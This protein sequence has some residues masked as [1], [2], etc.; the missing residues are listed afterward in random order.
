[1]SNGPQP[2][3]DFDA[4]NKEVNEG[5]VGPDNVLF[6]KAEKQIVHIRWAIR[7]DMQDIVHTEN[8]ASSSPGARKISSNAFGNAIAFPLSQN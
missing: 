1:M 7:R 3:E 4:L 8:R 5:L 6:K 2:A